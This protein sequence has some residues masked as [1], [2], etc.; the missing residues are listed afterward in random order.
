MDA[1]IITNFINRNKACP[2]DSYLLLKID[3]FVDATSGNERT[4]FINTYL[5]Y[6]QIQMD[7]SNGFILHLSPRGLF[8]YKVMP[9]DLKNAGAT[10]QRMINKIF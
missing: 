6:N 10:Y 4:S 9:F 2:K 5:G 8:C 1:T 3:Q 7:E